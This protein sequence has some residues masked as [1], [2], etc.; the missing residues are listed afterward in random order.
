MNNILTKRLF[1]LGA[2]GV[3]M[4]ACQS[5]PQEAQTIVATPNVSVE[6]T[7]EVLDQETISVPQSPSMAALRWQEFYADPKLKTLIEI[8][9]DNNKD[10]QRAILSVQSVRAKYQIQDAADVP[11]VGMSAGATR[12]ANGQDKNSRATYNVGLAMSGYELDL[13]G[14]VANAKESALHEYL[15][16]NAAKDAVQISLISSIAQ[17]Y[18]ALS[19]ALAQ[20]HLAISTLKTREHS[21][22]IATA[23]FKAGVDAKT[24]SLQ[25]QASLEGAKL[26][27]YT[28]ET[29]ILQARNAL[30]LL[31]GVPIPDEL[32]PE[33]AVNNLT[34]QTL[35][36]A[37]LPSELL[38][39]RPDIVQAEHTL[40]GAGANI[41]VA[42][43]AYFP[44][45]SLSGNLGFSSTSL[46]DLLKSSAFGWSFGPS[47]SLP[48]FDAGLR[49]ANY[50]M[51]QIAQKSA[52]TAYEKAI[53][54]AFK[55][56]ND[57][58][59]V[60]ATLGQQLQTQYRLQ[61]NYQETH[62]IA[63][64]RFRAGLDNYLGVLDAE[65]SLF[66]NQQNILALERQK[67][68]SQIQLYQA[69]GGGATLSAEQIVEFEQQ[70]EAMRTASIAT[71]EQQR[72]AIDQHKVEVGVAVA[73]PKPD[74]PRDE[75]QSA[76]KMQPELPVQ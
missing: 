51:A 47:I 31:L 50:E 57:V 12:L 16:T 5:I 55:E 32:I 71:Q 38:Y 42:R 62:N 14:K 70:R 8:G 72:Q 53:Q 22:A 46:Q 59:A 15:G 45:I 48:I 37:G 44:S 9:L 65:R 11:Q 29:E 17:G 13:W 74:E 49:H 4:T 39:Y 1:V 34:T 68:I 43:A 19:Y 61:K 69:L 52:L 35:F 60:R 66:A 75:V 67:V 33:M 64:A 36:S 56:V 3:A 2:L 73:Q 28:A 10:L 63:H 76:E 18:V 21:L 24:P 7:F 30:Q 54:T 25:A 41:N 27:V 40:R 6:E 20:R 58:L 26:A 23:R